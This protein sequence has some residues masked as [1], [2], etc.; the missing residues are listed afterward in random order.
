MAQCVA[1]SQRT[2]E[3]CKRSASAG[4]STCY[5]HGPA[6]G[7]VKRASARRRVGAKSEAG[8]AVE[9]TLTTKELSKRTWPDYVRFFSQGHGWDH[10]GCTAYQ[11]FRPPREVRAWSDKRDWSLDVKCQLVENHRAH[12]VLVYDG[13]DPVGW[14]QFGPESELPIRDGGVRRRRLFGDDEEKKWRITC[15]CTD[16]DYA[17]SGVAGMAL[18]GSLEAIARRGGGLVEA[19]PVAH[20]NLDEAAEQDRRTLNRWYNK[21]ARL[22]R[23]Q[24]VDEEVLERHIADAPPGV[25][26]AATGETYELRGVTLLELRGGRRLHIDGVGTVRATG[27][28]R[29]HGGTVAMFLRE[30]FTAVSVLPAPARVR[31]PDAQPSRV[32][33][34]RIVQSSTR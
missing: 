16:P 31:N 34:Q 15:F 32:V 9:R 23:S 2:G 22:C 7:Q 3:R 8:A 13:T 33:M 20:V 24:P 28:G 10:C 26:V 6:A 14:C 21:F 4:A 5:Y 11:G 12:G 18:R 27:F 19:W 30:G 29:F 25:E 1:R 17:G